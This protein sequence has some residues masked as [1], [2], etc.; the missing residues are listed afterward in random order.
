MLSSSFSRALPGQTLALHAEA[1]RAGVLPLPRHSLVHEP[2]C[3]SQG[4]SP[5]ARVHRSRPTKRSHTLKRAAPQDASGS[6]T[7]DDFDL[8]QYVEAKVE[9]GEANDLTA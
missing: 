7:S 6:D 9:R 3:S 1:R 4:L 5:F 2:A 8:T